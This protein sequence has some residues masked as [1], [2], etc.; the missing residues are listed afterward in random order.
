MKRL[1]TWFDEYKPLIIGLTIIVLL[2]KI[3]LELI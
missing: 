3:Y 1:K 2:A